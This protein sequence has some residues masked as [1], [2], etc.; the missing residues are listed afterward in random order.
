[1]MTTFARW[2]LYIAS[3]KIVYLIVA[4]CVVFNR[5]HG[6]QNNEAFLSLPFV[7][8]VRE[9]IRADIAILL[10]LFFLFV[11]SI[12]WTKYIKSWK[13]NTRIR[14]KMNSDSKIE[15]AAFILPY[16]FTIITINLDVYGW[17]V[18]ILI[19]LCVGLLFVQSK[20]VQMSPVFIL[21]RYNILTNGNVKLITRDSVEAF[22]LKLDDHPDGIQV[23]ELTKGV[24]IA[25]DQ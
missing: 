11:F 4:F 16:A 6:F 12:V 9:A 24:Y 2:L 10:I 20:K 8:K 25:L 13:N 18:C 1:M 14:L 15:E 23:R 19:Y 7:D 3:Y 5:F 22:N 17:M 21:S